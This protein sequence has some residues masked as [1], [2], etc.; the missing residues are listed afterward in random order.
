MRKVI[1]EGKFDKIMNTHYSQ[2]MRVGRTVFVAGQLPVDDEFNI[3]GKGDVEVQ[4]RKVLENIQ[5]VLQ[6]AGATMQDVVRIDI[7]VLDIRDLPRLAAARREF[8]GANRP[9][10]TLV[11]VSKLV[12]PDALVEI[13][14]IAM[15]DD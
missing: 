6:E 1:G 9:T 7:F 15:L 3:V 2:G 11:E 8:F 4:V 10:A 13:S 12:H 14:A 5:E